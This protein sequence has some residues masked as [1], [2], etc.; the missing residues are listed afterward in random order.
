MC[1]GRVK[2]LD[3]RDLRGR[4]EMGAGAK[5]DEIA[6]LVT[7][8]LR[9]ALVADELYACLIAIVQ[10]GALGRG[11]ATAEIG[12]GDAAELVEQPRQRQVSRQD[13]RLGD[14]GLA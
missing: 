6:L 5:V 9:S 8:H 7:G 12:L 14:R 13:G 1:R 4:R 3:G 11:A 10:R 2:Q